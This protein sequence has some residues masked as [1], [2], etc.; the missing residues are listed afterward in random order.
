MP[1]NK[2]IASVIAA[3]L[4]MAAPGVG[5]GPSARPETVSKH[6][7]QAEPELQ[8]PPVDYRGDWVQ[9]GTFSIADDTAAAGAKELHVVYIAKENLRHYHATGRFAEGTML[10]KDVRAAKTETLTTGTTSYAGDLLGRFVMV[11]RASNG[12]SAGSPR[13]GDGWA[14]AFFEGS[15]TQRTVTRDYR[16][17][18]LSCHEPA[19]SSDLVYVQGYP[20]LRQ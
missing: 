11:K 19:R 1:T 14:W 4:I 10:I 3:M 18:C 13:F 5:A 15:E 2:T 7:Q 9:L 8:I 12:S 16:A 20:V 6:A 17:D